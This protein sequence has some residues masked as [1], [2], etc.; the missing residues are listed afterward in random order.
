MLLWERG[1]ANQ[2]E[3]KHA[4]VCNQKLAL[5]HLADYLSEV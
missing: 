5:H 2:A 1:F 4:M 3:V